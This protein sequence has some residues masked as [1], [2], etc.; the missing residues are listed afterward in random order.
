MVKSTRSPFDAKT[1]Q[2]RCQDLP[3]A[4]TITPLGSAP[5]LILVKISFYVTAYYYLSHLSSKSFTG[6]PFNGC[7]LQFR[8]RWL[9]RS[10]TSSRIHTTPIMSI[11]STHVTH[12]PSS[13]TNSASYKCHEALPRW[14]KSGVETGPFRLCC[15]KLLLG[16]ARILDSDLLGCSV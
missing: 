16:P 4:Q 14:L 3:T 10:V 7:N 6:F 12:L 11:G 2:W 9:N 8:T 1:L 13:T 15:Q 5:N